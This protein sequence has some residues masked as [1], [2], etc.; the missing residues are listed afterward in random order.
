MSSLPVRAGS[1]LTQFARR[2]N[3]R[4]AMPSLPG[5][6]K[7]IRTKTMKKVL[8]HL[9]GNKGETPPSPRAPER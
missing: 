4:Y 5:T 7:G 8:L 3:R 6:P 1:L 9:P 2:G